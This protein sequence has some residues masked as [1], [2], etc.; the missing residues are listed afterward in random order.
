MV[1]LESYA[2]IITNNIGT[3]AFI[4]KVEKDYFFSLQLAFDH[5]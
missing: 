4:L 2:F 3:I 5:F 1:V